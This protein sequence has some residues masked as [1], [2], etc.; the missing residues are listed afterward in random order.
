[1]PSELNRRALLAAAAAFVMALA[2]AYALGSTGQA[3]EGTGSPG[4]PATPLDVASGAAAQST[5]GEAQALP[6]LVARPK[7]PPPPEPEPDETVTTEEAPPYVAPPEQVY[8]PPAPTV[9]PTP[10]PTPTPEPGGEFD[11]SG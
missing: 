5:I 4:S 6:Q 9:T 11:D 8:D 10:T 2:V 7:P 1:M 3:S